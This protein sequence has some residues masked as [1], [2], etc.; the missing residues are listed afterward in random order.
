M[1]FIFYGLRWFTLMIGFA[2]A[3]IIPFM[4]GIQSLVGYEWPATG[5]RGGGLPSRRKGNGDR[6]GNANSDYRRH[7]G[8]DYVCG[9]TITHSAHYE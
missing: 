1:P 9:G 6:P 4:S 5:T 3:S 2:I 7:M 8:N